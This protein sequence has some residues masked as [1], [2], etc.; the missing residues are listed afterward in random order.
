MA[1]QNYILRDENAIYYECGYS[2]DYALFLKLGSEAF[3]ITDGRYALDAKEKIKNA[4]VIVDRNLQERVAHLINSNGVKKIHFDPKEWSVASF[5]LLRSKCDIDWIEVVDFSHQKRI[6]KTQ[7]EQQLLAKAASKGAKA[8]KRFID[9][10]ATNGILKD[11]YQLADM[12]R[13]IMTYEGRY[14]VSFEPIVAINANAAKPHA[15]PTSQK[16]S[17]GDLLL[18]DAGLKYKRYCSD[19]TRTLF[20]GKT[21]C[22]GLGQSFGHKQH[23]KIYDIVRKAHDVAIAKARVGMKACEID[24]MA[25][26]VIEKAGFGEFFVHSTGHGVGLDI[27]ELPYISS[28]SETI[29][30]EG[31][32]FT[33]EPG[34][35][36][37]NKFGVRI[38]DMVVMQNNRAVIL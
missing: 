8:F 10:I 34:I 31:M 2:C 36:L 22:G 32:V 16:L 38:E 27:H 1:P 21:M 35:Y 15:Y 20:V 25:R 29:I 12:V 18:I 33:I 11:E 7:K 30:E 9:K 19:R 4:S 26:G 13:H 6:I 28:K 23:Q 5:G 24:A 14:E 3:F 37:P 17:K